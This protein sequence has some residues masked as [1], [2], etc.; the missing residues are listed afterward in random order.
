GLGLQMVWTKMFSAG[1]G[2][3]APAMLALVTAFLGGMALGAWALDGRIHRSPDPRRWYAKLQLCIGAWAALVTL[4]VPQL[5]RLAI[6]LMGADAS[7]LRQALV[8]FAI[9][10]LALLPATAA[11][12]ATLPAMERWLAALTTEV[13]SLARVYAWNTAGA[14]AGT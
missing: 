7:P 8:A 6:A 12:G 4:L 14:V 1:L 9:P 11:M 5:N 3:E 13:P 2:H 10:F